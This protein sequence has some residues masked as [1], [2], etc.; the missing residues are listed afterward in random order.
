MPPSRMDPAPLVTEPYRIS[1][2]PQTIQAWRTHVQPSHSEYRPPISI[3]SWGIAHERPWETSSELVVHTTYTT[4]NLGGELFFTR[5]TVTSDVASTLVPSVRPSVLPFATEP[6]GV[7]PVRPAD[8]VT[9]PES[10]AERRPST[11]LLRRQPGTIVADPARALSV[12]PPP[13]APPPSPI[14]NISQYLGSDDDDSLSSSTTPPPAQRETPVQRA[15][16]RTEG[17]CF[18]TAE[19]GNE[20]M[21]I[22]QQCNK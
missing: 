8:V 20:Y 21:N 6:V 18:Y 19:G 22:K 13:P 1:K 17:T 5:D 10:A 14:P 11:P 9:A 7:W 16:R 3:Q 15:H 4:P 2:S 12:H